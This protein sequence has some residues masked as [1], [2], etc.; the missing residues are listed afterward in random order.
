MTRRRR[1]PSIRTVELGIRAALVCILSSVYIAAAMAEG[2]RGQIGP[3]PAPPE[4]DEETVKGLPLALDDAATTH[5]GLVVDIA[6]LRNDS[7]PDGDGLRV[8]S[9]TQGRNGS[10]LVN[11]DDTIRYQ[12]NAGFTGLDGFAYTIADGQGNTAGAGVS[13]TVKDVAHAPV[14]E[15]QAV[16]T[17]E[18]TALVITL[19]GSDADGDRLTFRIER[20]PAKGSLSGAPPDLSYTPN[21]DYNG[22]DSFLFAADDGHGESHTGKVSI[23]IHAVSD[24]P[25]ALDDA[26]TTHEGLVVDIAVLRNDSD[27]DG[28][29]LRVVS[30]TQGTNGSVLINGDDTIR[31]QPNAGF[32]GLDGFAYTIADGQGTT[33]TAAV[34]VRV[35]DVAE[36]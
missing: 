10:V 23:K 4:A 14:A 17:D 11:G 36:R 29:G 30:V 27:P 8:V 21:V 7:D 33:A 5:E 18:D 32:T 19:V 12:P 2:D 13:V 25:L 1:Y 6:V 16:E 31:Y 3:G 35:Q 9:V 28:D 34:S 22:P 24:A 20:L 15:D 26:A